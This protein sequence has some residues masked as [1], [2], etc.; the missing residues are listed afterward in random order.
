MYERW[1]PFVIHQ[2]FSRWSSMTECTSA[3]NRVSLF[4]VDKDVPL[5]SH[6]IVIYQC[7]KCRKLSAIDLYDIR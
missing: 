4:F 6:I 1:L 5:W 3:Y 2:P 7:F